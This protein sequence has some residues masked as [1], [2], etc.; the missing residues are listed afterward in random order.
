MHH[1][2]DSRG[3]LLAWMGLPL[4]GA[5]FFLWDLSSPTRDGNWAPGSESTDLNHWITR[6]KSQDLLVLKYRES[7]KELWHLGDISV[8]KHSR[9]CEGSWEN[10]WSIF[11]NSER[12]VFQVFIDDCYPTFALKVSKGGDSINSFDNVWC[13]HIVLESVSSSWVLIQI[14][15]LQSGLSFLSCL[16]LSAESVCSHLDIC[17]HPHP[18]IYFDLLKYK[19]EHCVSS[20]G[21]L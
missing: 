2:V 17:L 1:L 12:S 5:F 8:Q 7:N 4:L 18:S 6:V 9:C 15:M 11:L 16:C 14:F 19:T 3:T 10:S 13:C 21:S 20:A